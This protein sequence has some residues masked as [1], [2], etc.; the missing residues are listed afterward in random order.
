MT[1]TGYALSV[2]FGNETSYGTA[3]TVNQPIGLVQACNPTENNN[4]IKVRTLGGTRDYAAIVPGKFSISGTMDYY[5]QGGAFLRQ[6][7]GEDT[8]TSATVDSGPKIHTGA[9]YRHCMGSAAS[10]GSDS[11]PSFVLEVADSEDSGAAAGTAN[12]KRK[13]RGCR[14]NTLTISGTVDEPVKVAV[15]WQAQSV[16]ISTAAATSVS[17]STKDPYVF[18]QGAVY[19]T[20]GAIRATT[21]LVNA[22]TS[23]IAEVNTFSIGVNNNLEA[24][25]YISGTTSTQQP[26]RGL[27]NLFVK[28]RD[29]TASLGLHFKNRKIYQKFLG[30]VSATSPANGIGKYQIALDL[31]RSGYPGSSPRVATD[32][33]IRIA[34]GSASFNTINVAGGPEDIIGQQLDIFVKNAKIWVVDADADYK[35]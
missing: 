20:S 7:M 18:Y 12:L 19:L 30:S 4:L 13:F 25:W 31:T 5:L 16:N 8:G 34:L 15:D 35:A 11:F 14:V 9:S 3:G 24:V 23:E 26:L 33:W 32:D 17:Q 22:T 2:N 10:P 29:Y 1:N 6:A 27:K 28:G 21:S